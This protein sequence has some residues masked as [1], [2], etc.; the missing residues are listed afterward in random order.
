MNLYGDA[1]IDLVVTDY[2]DGQ[3]RKHRDAVMRKKDR[4][5]RRGWLSLEV[6]AVQQDA[7]LTQAILFT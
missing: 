2:K 5:R 6:N 1:E 7:I 3:L 4:K